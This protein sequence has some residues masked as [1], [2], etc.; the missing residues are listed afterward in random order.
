MPHNATYYQQIEALWRIYFRYIC[1][2]TGSSLV[3]VIGSNND[4]SP[5]RGQ[6]YSITLAKVDILSVERQGTIFSEFQSRNE[7]FQSGEWMWKFRLWNGVHFVSDS[8]CES[9]LQIQQPHH[10]HGKHF[11]ITLQ[12][13][14]RLQRPAI[15]HSLKWHAIHRRLWFARFSTISEKW[16]MVFMFINYLKYLKSG[17]FKKT[18]SCCEAAHHEI[19]P[20]VRSHYLKIK[21]WSP[22]S[23]WQHKHDS[24]CIRTKGS[25]FFLSNW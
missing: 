12:T 5:V 19:L 6:A 24:V 13:R 20:Y 14:Y 18:I 1:Q 15:V 4:I 16:K 7:Y 3:Q 17:P 8:M 21:C 11:T 9:Y 22:K 2:W 25:Y 23:L 10:A